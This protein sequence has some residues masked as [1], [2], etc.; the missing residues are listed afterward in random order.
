VDMFSTKAKFMG[1]ARLIWGEPKVPIPGSSLPS[2][3]SP[4]QLP[5]MAGLT[6]VTKALLSESTLL[7]AK[8]ICFLPSNCMLLV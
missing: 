7:S 3:T 5:L 2:L 1:L 4:T 8:W 6:G